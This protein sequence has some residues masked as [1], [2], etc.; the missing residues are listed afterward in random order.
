MNKMTFHSKGN[1][2]TRKEN[3]VSNYMEDITMKFL[4]EEKPQRKSKTA[5]KKKRKKG[6]G[7]HL[8]HIVYEDQIEDKFETENELVNGISSD[9]SPKVT[10]TELK[11]IS[12]KCHQILKNSGNKF[13]DYQLK[14]NDVLFKRQLLA[15]F[16]TV[17]EKYDLE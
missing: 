15:E 3:N 9:P 16:R 2:L 10:Q 1:F 8:F 12:N 13:M 5:E 7:K 6:K 4:N 14:S 11:D 17:K